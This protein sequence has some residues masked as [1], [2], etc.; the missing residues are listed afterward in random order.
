MIAR[1]GDSQE[2]CAASCKIVL[3]LVFLVF[4]KEALQ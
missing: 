2:T 4:Y 3:I 1:F